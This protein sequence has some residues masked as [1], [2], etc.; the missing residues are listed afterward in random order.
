M[1]ENT[2]PVIEA[3]KCPKCGAN[4]KFN[5]NICT[6]CNYSKIPPVIT[7]PPQSRLVWEKLSF[8]L[9]GVMI[10]ALLAL[11]VTMPLG[12]GLTALYQIDGPFLDAALKC[13]DMILYSHYATAGICVAMAAA[14]AVMMVRALKDKTRLTGALHTTAIFQA[15]AMWTFPVV[16]IATDLIIT[17]I[18]KSGGG[19]LRK[20]T[21]FDLFDMAPIIWVPL[22]VTVVALAIIYVNDRLAPQD[23]FA[24]EE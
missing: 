11:A 5:P 13:P 23:N 6:S 21:A 15:V 20:P 2:T 7:L 17:S 22:I 24:D 10:V 9:I 18:R 1:N 14:A 8:I 12:F 3:W 4:N 16:N 19:Q